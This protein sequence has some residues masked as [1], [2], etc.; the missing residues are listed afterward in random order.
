MTRRW[1]VA[2]TAVLAI[3]ALACEGG[4]GIGEPTPPPNSPRP[5]LPSA[6]AALGDSITNGFGSCLVLA[7]CRR[8]SWSTGDGQRVESH[9]RRLLAANPAIDGNTHNQASSGARVAALSEQAAAAVR[10][11][12]DY[13]TVL[14]GANDACRS[15]IDAMTS[16]A[17]F[18]SGVDRALSTLKQG[19]PRARVLVVSIPN[20]YRLWEIGHP[21]ERVTRAWG[22]GI[23]PALLANPT[24]TAEA[25]V[26]RRAEFRA[27]IAAYN[28]QLSA[29]CRAYGSRCR[30]DGGA[31][32]Q[33]RFTLDMLNSLDYFHPNAAGQSKLAEVTWAKSGFA[34]RVG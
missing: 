5:G 17:D 11:K 26:R 18:R 30:Y 1:T 33:A 23:C 6:M 7:A 25:D 16:V 9:Y 24:S 10:A 12:V 21:E 34:D 29:A 19:R 32:H 4:G 22:R 31:A 28:D 14:I 27:R 3:F 15:R 13:V 20:L 8:N 2:V